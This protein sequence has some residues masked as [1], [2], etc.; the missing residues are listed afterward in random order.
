VERH[1]LYVSLAP[2]VEHPKSVEPP[3]RSAQRC[4]EH[5]DDEEGGTSTA[6]AGAE[7]LKSLEEPPSKCRRTIQDWSEDEA[8]EDA[9]AMLNP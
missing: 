6:N 1:T 9:S 7:Q 2:G 5:V 4:Y 3:L 8:E